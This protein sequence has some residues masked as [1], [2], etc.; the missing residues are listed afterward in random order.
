MKS[1]RLILFL[2]AAVCLGSTLHGQAQGP[3]IMRQ[4]SERY[5]RKVDKVI[6]DFIQHGKYPDA[7]EVLQL[8]TLEN[9]MLGLAIVSA[10]LR[11]EM[12]RLVIAQGLPLRALRYLP[13]QFVVVRLEAAGL[14][15]LKDHLQGRMFTVPAPA[16]K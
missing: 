1:S 16:K 10:D 2:T 13:G 5:E 11:A 8:R 7:T 15:P 4:T 3:S 12:P 9:D 6:T 14:D